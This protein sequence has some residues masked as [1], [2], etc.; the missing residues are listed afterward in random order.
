[1]DRK[2]HQSC[3]SLRDG[4]EKIK[5]RS[6]E[7]QEKIMVRNM[8]TKHGSI[9]TIVLMMFMIFGLAMGLFIVHKVVSEIIPTLEAKYNSTYADSGDS[10]IWNKVTRTKNTVPDNVFFGMFVGA[11]LV[12]IV[13]A[14][15]TPTHPVFMGIFILIVIIVVTVSAVLSNTWMEFEENDAWD[16]TREFFDKTDHVMNYLPWYFATMGTI[17]LVILY[18]RKTKSEKGFG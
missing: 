12:L 15:M 5:K 6:I 8:K 14:F 17:S 18:V 2:G 9:A 16:G 11:L 7:E 13:G 10:Q 4:S 3:E 1:M